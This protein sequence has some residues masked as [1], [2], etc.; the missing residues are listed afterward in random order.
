MIE[1]A[2]RRVAGARSVRERPNSSERA[3]KY[4]PATVAPAAASQPLATS[5]ATT[6]VG[7]S[8]AAVAIITRSGA[9][10][11]GHRAVPSASPRRR[12][13]RDTSRLP[14]RRRQ[15]PEE[16]PRRERGGARSSHGKAPADHRRA[17][18]IAPTTVFQAV[19]VL[20]GETRTHDDRGQ[21]R[22]GAA[23]NREQ[24]RE[25]GSAM[26]APNAAA[27]SVRSFLRA[28]GDWPC[29]ACGHRAA[30]RSAD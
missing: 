8:A 20:S 21:G 10:R 4:T 14:P 19:T 15:L 25:S 30:A 2:E 29:G 5:A 23:G 9:A 13:R 7:T 22:Q 16:A 3:R 28:A 18:G 26:P 17:A 6:P 1:A 27:S 12:S 11:W 24:V